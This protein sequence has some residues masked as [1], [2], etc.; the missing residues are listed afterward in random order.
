MRRF[1]RRTWIVSALLA[2]LAAAT[3]ALLISTT[4]RE[5][6]SAPTDTATD[7]G[8]P[9]A[10]PEIQ[11]RN[12]V[13]ILFNNDCFMPGFSAPSF[14]ANLCRALHPATGDESRLEAL[15]ALREMGAVRFVPADAGRL[16]VILRDGAADTR[17]GLMR[18]MR[19]DSE[20]GIRLVGLICDRDRMRLFIWGEEIPLE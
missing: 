7:A 17:I 5:R 13:W 12:R 10:T 4:Y 6:H 1:T 8:L 15:L 18:G 9:E 3:F 11:A 16:V 20:L 14:D 19:A 2:L